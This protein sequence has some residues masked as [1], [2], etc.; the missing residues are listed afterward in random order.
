MNWFKSLFN[1]TPESTSKG[2]KPLKP[3]E[4]IALLEKRVDELSKRISEVEEQVTIPF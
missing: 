2:A 3:D 1:R 4:R